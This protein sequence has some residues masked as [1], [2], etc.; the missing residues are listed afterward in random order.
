MAM[1][2]G[3]VVVVS[4]VDSKSNQPIEFPE[5]NVVVYHTVSREIL[6]RVLAS[7]KSPSLSNESY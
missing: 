6:I 4:L 7:R 1:D 3:T 5:F 2:A